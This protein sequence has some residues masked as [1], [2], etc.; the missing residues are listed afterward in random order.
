M[1]LRLAALGEL[2]AAVDAVAAPPVGSDR[3]LWVV[4]V[5]EFGGSGVAEVSDVLGEAD[6]EFVGCLFPA[7]V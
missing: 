5:E 1:R 6:A 3:R 7:G 4:A 2:G